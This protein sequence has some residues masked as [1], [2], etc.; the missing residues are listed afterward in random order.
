[1]ADALASRDDL[2]MIAGNP[3]GT[4]VVADR[5]RLA[6]NEDPATQTGAAWDAQLFHGR[7]VGARGP[8][9]DEHTRVLEDRQRGDLGA[10]QTPSFVRGPLG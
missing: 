1:L 9:Q 6:F 10:D 4:R 3:F 8:A 5:Q 7:R 2:D